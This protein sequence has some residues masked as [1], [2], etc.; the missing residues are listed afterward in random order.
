M[1]CG[2]ANRQDAARGTQWPRSLRFDYENKTN[3]ERVLCADVGDV[4]WDRRSR[5][6]R[7]QSCGSVLSSLLVTRRALSETETAQQSQ[8][9][10]TRWLNGGPADGGP[11]LIQHWLNVLYLLEQLLT[12][13]DFNLLNSLIPFISL[14]STW[15]ILKTIR[16]LDMSHQSN[17]IFSFSSR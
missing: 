6:D 8:E 4:R 14:C 16:R 5:S 17:G 2:K 9:M 10:E 12:Q 11:T 1:S 7:D 15:H 3:A 13:S